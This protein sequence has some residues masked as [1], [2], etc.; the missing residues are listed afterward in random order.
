[1]KFVENGLLYRGFRPVMWSPVEKT[2]LAEAEVEYHEKTSPTIYVK[3][4]LVEGVA[5]SFAQYRDLDHHALDHSGQSR[6]RLLAGD[7]LR[8]LSGG[9]RRRWQRW[10]ESGETDLLL[11]DTLA[12]QVAKHAKMMLIARAHVSSRRTQGA[13]RGASLPQPGL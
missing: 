13:G 1:M 7:F 4:P 3:F 9:R 6:H 5:R 11:A 12:E 10:R 8:P 2:A